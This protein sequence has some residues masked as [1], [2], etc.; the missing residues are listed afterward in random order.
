M[1]SRILNYNSLIRIQKLLSAY[2]S[3]ALWISR[4]FWARII[5]NMNDKVYQLIPR[6]EIYLN[7]WFVTKRIFFDTC[8]VYITVIDC[9]V[10]LVNTD[11]KARRKYRTGLDYL[12]SSDL[13]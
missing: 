2:K 12:K 8:D 3:G 11:H 13:R 7:V 6:L 9:K 10:N 1:E 4:V 5:L